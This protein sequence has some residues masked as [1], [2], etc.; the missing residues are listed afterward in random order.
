[1]ALNHAADSFDCVWVVAKLLA[2]LEKQTLT[3]LVFDPIRVLCKKT[4]LTH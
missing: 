2:H 4:L 1:M 3:D